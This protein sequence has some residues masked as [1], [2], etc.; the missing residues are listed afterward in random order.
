MEH[1]TRL[2]SIDV[3]RALTMFLMIFVN[4]VD[5]VRHI[6]LWIKHVSADASGLGFADII[7]PAFL[8]IVGLSLP[9]AINGRLSRGCTR[10]NVSVYIS[11]RA[12][13][14]IIMGLFHVNFGGYNEQIAPLPRAVY[15]ILVT[16]SF[17]LVWLAYPKTMSGRTRL[18]WQGIG[19]LGLLLLA[20]L[21]RAGT[22]AQPKWMEPHW[23]GILGLIGWAYWLAALSYLYFGRRMRWMAALLVALSLANIAVHAQWITF[24]AVLVGDT[25]SAVL[26]VAGV[27]TTMVYLKHGQT[28]R[29]EMLTAGFVLAGVLAVLLAYGLAPYT[30]GINKIRATPAWVWMTLGISMLCFSA[31]IYGVDYRKKGHYFNWISA[32]GTNTLTCYLLPYILYACY[33]LF[34]VSF[35]RFLNEGMGGMVRSFAVAFFIVGV[36]GLL[37]RRG[38]RIK[39]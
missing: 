39:V 11:T 10:A 12:I 23:W 3:F 24:P 8:F 30:A 33:T 37:E 31:C 25:S 29:M 9:L 2:Q 20:L 7:F 14:L 19:V 32:A 13:A 1:P 17:F 35:P 16:L 5:G 15:Q 34:D 4:D 27:V 28:A 26:V 6:P 18:I 38:I 21:Y 22:E 36:A